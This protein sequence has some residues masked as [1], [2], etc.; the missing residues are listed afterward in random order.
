[1]IGVDFGLFVWGDK[2]SKI[3]F[4]KMINENEKKKKKMRKDKI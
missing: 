3:F 4:M 1:V 2:K